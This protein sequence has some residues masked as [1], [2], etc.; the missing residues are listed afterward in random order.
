MKFKCGVLASAAICLL[1]MGAS[2]AS[3]LT[4]DLTLSNASGQVGSGSFTVAGPVASSG[5]EVFTAGK[6]GGL[7]DLSFSI[8][9][10]TFNLTSGLFFAP[11]VTFDNGILTNIS[12]IGDSTTNGFKLDLGTFGLAYALTNLGSFQI[13]SGSISDR[14]STTPLPTGLPLFITGLAALAL[15]GWKKKQNL[16]AA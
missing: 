7:T 5:L 12:Y 11:T 9:S 13:S 10:N 14:V 6:G 15:I 3:A 4:Y 2:E 16:Q 1:A 8:G